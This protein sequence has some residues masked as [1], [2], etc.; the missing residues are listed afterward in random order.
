VSRD[1]TRALI[2]G[3]DIVFESISEK[4]KFVE[5]NIGS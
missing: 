2:G 3:G 1:E 4:N 5:E